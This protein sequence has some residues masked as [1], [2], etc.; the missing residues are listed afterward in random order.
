[1]ETADDP[2]VRSSLIIQTQTVLYFAGGLMD[3]L[4]PGTIRQ[5]YVYVT[6]TLAAM[7]LAFHD[8]H[9]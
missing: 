4:L 3:F 7:K 1:M 5:S 2:L 9:S 6:V 8:L